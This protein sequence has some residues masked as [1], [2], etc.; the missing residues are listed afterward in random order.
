[1]AK[2]DELLKKLREML[3]EDAVTGDDSYRTGVAATA[4]T[5]MESL[6]DVTAACKE[7]DFFLETMTGLDFEDTA[8]VVY[9]FNAYE[10]KSR[11]AVRMMCSHDGTAPTVCDIFAAAEWLEREVHEFYGIR[12]A[13]NPDLRRLLLPEDADFYPLKKTFGNVHAYLRREEIYG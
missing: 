1:M 8:E 2:K 6:R 13:D 9:H 11:I 4:M 10:P 3:G 12:F 5:P 7:G